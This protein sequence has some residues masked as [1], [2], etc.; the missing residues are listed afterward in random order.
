M[1]KL[2]DHKLSM[3]QIVKNINVQCLAKEKM[4][5]F[6]DSAILVTIYSPWRN[7]HTQ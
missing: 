7:V 3:T 6:N 1:I 4:H 5:T 2:A